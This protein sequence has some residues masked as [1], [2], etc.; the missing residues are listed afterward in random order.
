MKRVFFKDFDKV[1]KFGIQLLIAFLFGI[2]V[3]VLGWSLSAK[4]N[5]Q[6][7]SKPVQ[8]GTPDEVDALMEFRKQRPLLG[9]VANVQFE[10]GIFPLPVIFWYGEE[11]SNFHMVEY[12]FAMDQACVISVGDNID[13]DV[14][15]LV[16]DRKKGGWQ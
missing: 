11:E 10:E 1:D 15:D 14:E 6:W 12:N 5:P 16:T 8:C 9:G 3:I 13:F 7:V 2:G 4:A